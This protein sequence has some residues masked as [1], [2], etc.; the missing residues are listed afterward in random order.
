MQLIYYTRLKSKLIRFFCNLHTL[1][2][3][4]NVQEHLISNI[5]NT[6]NLHNVHSL[7]PLLT[8]R[9]SL[10]PKSCN[11]RNVHSLQLS[12][13]RVQDQH[14]LLATYVTYTACNGL[15]GTLLDVI[16]LA[17]Y[18]TYTAC[19][20]ISSYFPHMIPI[21]Q[22]MC[23]TQLATAKAYKFQSYILYK[24]YKSSARITMCGVYLTEC[25]IIKTLLIR[26]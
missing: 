15:K 12:T 10:S 17:T 16:I 1:Y 19:N 9:G 20:I 13:F 24:K 8:V 22:P 4:C 3:A 6:C 18:V 21:L 11:L 25:N 23:R 26:F 5:I 14:D 2:M 7:Q